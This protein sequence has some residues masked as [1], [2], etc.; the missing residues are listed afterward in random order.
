MIEIGR[1]MP[2]LGGGTNEAGAVKLTIQKFYRIAGGSTQLKGVEPDVKVP[3]PYDHPE[4][5]EVA[6]KGPLPYDT[7]E[8]VPFDKVEKPL[9][10]PELRQRS[11]ARIAVDPEFRYITDDLDLVK[12]RV[13][14]N[15]ISLNI[16]KRRAEIEDEKSR[17]EKRTAERATRTVPQPKRFAVTLDTL[18]KQE[19]QLVTNEKKKDATP[20]VEKA[21][22]DDDD[23]D[24]DST[25]NPKPV[26]DAVRNEALNILADFVD[27]SHGV[28]PAATASTQAK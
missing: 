1:V 3:S 7:V 19:L 9:F 26:V 2:F 21:D 13:A 5:G 24:D 14:E 6:L 4:I 27:L 23:E 28:K 18:G 12:K 15:K 10:K 16:E 8:A 22:G 17:K 20:D 25:K 11:A